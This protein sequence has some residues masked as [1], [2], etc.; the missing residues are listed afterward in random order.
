M[1][2]SY[3]VSYFLLLVKTLIPITFYFIYILPFVAT[4][5]LKDTCNSATY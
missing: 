1:K 5:M 4:L 2:N 3:S